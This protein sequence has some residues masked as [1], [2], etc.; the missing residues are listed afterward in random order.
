MVKVEI[1]IQAMQTMGRAWVESNGG[2]TKH[3]KDHNTSRQALFNALNLA[4]RHV[5]AWVVEKVCE[6][7]EITL[8][9][10][11]YGGFLHK[12]AHYKAVVN[13]TE[14]ER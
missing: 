7:N 14:T 5:P 12:T 8:E 4:D 10:N 9:P 13:N 1:S 6:E 2:Y 3:A 11:G